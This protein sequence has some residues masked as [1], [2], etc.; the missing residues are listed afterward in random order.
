MVLD[1][2]QALV[3]PAVVMTLALTFRHQLADLIGRVIELSGGGVSIKV[4]KAAKKAEEIV[5]EL[6]DDAL[7]AALPPEVPPRVGLESIL[8]TWSEIERVAREIAG[9]F[10]MNPFRSS[11]VTRVAAEAEHRG[12][13][14]LIAVQLASQMEQVRDHLVHSGG[15]GV[16]VDTAD[17]VLNSMAFLLGMLIGVRDRVATIDKGIEPVNH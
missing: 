11:L 6:P 2:V 10:K 9:L 16:T 17:S 8:A 12:Y 5:D 15:G 4:A 1:Y 7:T 3:W 13:L 14:E